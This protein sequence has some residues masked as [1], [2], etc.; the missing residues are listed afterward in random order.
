[1]Q[2]IGA[3]YALLEV[4][5]VEIRI[6]IE[7]GVCL[8]QNLGRRKRKKMISRPAPLP[9]KKIPTALNNNDN[10][11]INVQMT[12]DFYFLIAHNPELGRT[13]FKDSPTVQFVIYKM[14]A[15]LDLKNHCIVIKSKKGIIFLKRITFWHPCW[16]YLF[17]I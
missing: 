5:A 4:E 12:F 1:M 16:P 13:S 14:L 2:R 7:N 11:L 9:Q 17:D 6:R 3:S 8:G 15:M 10:Q